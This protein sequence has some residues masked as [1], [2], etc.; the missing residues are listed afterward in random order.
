[1]HERT[2]IIQFTLTQLLLGGMIALNIAACT[3]SVQVDK[4]L[5]KKQGACADA[6]TSSG[7]NSNNSK[8]F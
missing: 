2:S 7:A 4:I 8:K 1:M 6:S 5:S 3:S